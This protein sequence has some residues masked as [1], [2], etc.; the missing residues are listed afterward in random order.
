MKKLLSRLALLSSVVVLTACAPFKTAIPD[1]YTGP[2]AVLKDSANVMSTSKADM[3]YAL[4]VDDNNIDNM[5]FKTRR[6]N[7]GRGM[8]MNV[9]E[10]ER[11]IAAKQT[12]VSVTARTIYAAP[13][14]AIAGTVYQVQGDI[15]FTPE[16]NKSY[17]VR[18]ALDES[19]SAVWIE[20]E[21]TKT[22]VGEKVEIKGSAKLGFFEK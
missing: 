22:V 20:E 4:A 19:Y 12:K 18:G 1:G 7:E 10:A 9:V 14:L 6:Q 17:V 15:V 21:L 5:R 13:I 11:Q 3:Y 16:P 8:M 2:T